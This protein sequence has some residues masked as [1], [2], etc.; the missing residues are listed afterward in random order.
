MD[1]VSLSFVQS[2]KLAPCTKKKH[3]HIIP[4]VKGADKKSYIATYGIFHLVIEIRDPWNRIYRFTRLYVAIDRDII[5]AVLL[6]SRLV[7]RDLGI[8]IYHGED[9]KG[10]EAC[11][12]ACSRAIDGHCAHVLWEFEKNPRVERVSKKRFDREIR[13]GLAYVFEL[14]QVFRPA[15][16]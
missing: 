4:P 5:D 13:K 1:F 11:T 9:D 2:L 6:L 15:K 12:E 7:L 10:N 16:A 8:N 14:R 3:N